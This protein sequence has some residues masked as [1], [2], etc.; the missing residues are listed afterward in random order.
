[1]IVM[2]FVAI[3]LALSLAMAFAWIVQRRTG[4]S[5]WIDAIWSLATGGA[6]AAAAWLPAFAN[7]SRG[8]RSLLLVALISLW[9]ARLASHIALRTARGG[10]DPR[11]ADLAMQWG[12]AFPTRLFWFLQ[13][14]AVCGLVL[15]SCVFVASRNPAP[16]PDVF[17]ALGAAVFVAAM[18]GETI[19]DRQLRAFRLRPSNKGRICAT[20]LWGWSRHPNYFFECVIW[21]GVALVAIDPSGA[22]LRGWLA[23]AAPA[24]TYGLLA[25]VSGVPPLEASMARSRG[26]AFADYQSRVNVFFPGPPRNRR[27]SDA[28]RTSS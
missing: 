14:Q 12:A 18:A 15:A 7:E 17:D 16:F 9:G 2:N 11:Y 22:Y 24:L 23:L 4:K 26:A 6:G 28:R 8:P 20:G 13:I 21:I 1:M 19:A 25:H 10:E 5:G 27:A 3:G